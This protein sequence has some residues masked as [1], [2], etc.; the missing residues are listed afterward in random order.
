MTTCPDTDAII[1]IGDALDWNVAE[2]LRH[3]QTC[4]DCREQ[5][6]I[7][8]LTRSAFTQ[9][10][11][12]D[13]VVTRRVTDA[14]RVAANDEAVRT[15]RRR[16]WLAIAEPIA[17]GVTGLLLLRSGGIQI[18]SVGTAIVGFV[19]GALAI[20]G[21]HALARRIPALGLADATS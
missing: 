4:D 19:L 20:L 5:L 11:A 13:P 14:L 7:L 15:Q 10:E 8:E 1:A 17:A 6:E 2:G 9:T 3:L 16:R 18:E 12:I 21:G